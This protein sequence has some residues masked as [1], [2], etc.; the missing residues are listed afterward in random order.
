MYVRNRWSRIHIFHGFVSKLHIL[1]K[2]DNTAHWVIAYR[3]CDKPENFQVMKSWEKYEASFGAG[4]T[5][6]TEETEGNWW[7]NEE[8]PEWNSVE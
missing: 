4:L 3:R 7:L 1:H 6:L 2:S 8:N 5:P